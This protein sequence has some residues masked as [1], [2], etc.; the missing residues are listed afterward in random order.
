MLTACILSHSATTILS[1]TQIIVA[2]TTEY[3]ATFSIPVIALENVMTCRVHRAVVLGLKDQARPSFMLTP[4][5][6]NIMSGGDSILKEF[7]PS[8][9]KTIEGRIGHVEL[10]APRVRCT[11]T[12]NIF[13][14]PTRSPE[15]EARW[16]MH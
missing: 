12:W 8:S 15:P 16:A 9:H 2:T 13:D 14:A 10:G 6:S 5:I 3:Q 11:A 4:V 7:N 1:I